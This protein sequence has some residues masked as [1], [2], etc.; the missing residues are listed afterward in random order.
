[1]IWKVVKSQRQTNDVFRFQSVHAAWSFKQRAL[2]SAFFGFDCLFVKIR[3]VQ[4]NI[5]LSNVIQCNIFLKF[6]LIMRHK[7]GTVWTTSLRVQTEHVIP[8]TRYNLCLL[9]VRDMKCHPSFSFEN[10]AWRYCCQLRGYL[11]PRLVLSYFYQF[12]YPVLF[13]TFLGLFYKQ[14]NIL[15]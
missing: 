13:G 3:L 11:T 12:R 6:Y 10:W 8:N 4:C 9:Y 14:W 5:V 15:Q 1:M 7:F 2:M